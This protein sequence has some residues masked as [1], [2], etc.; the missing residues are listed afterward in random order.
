MEVMGKCFENFLMY[1]EQKRKL[2]CCEPRILLQVVSHALYE[3]R[4]VNFD[5]PRQ[6][7]SAILIIPFV[8]AHTNARAMCTRRITHAK[9]LLANIEHWEMNNGA[10]RNSGRY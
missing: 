7:P 3:L 2:A 10:D 6:R 5:Q 1:Y 4:A 8:L 9:Q